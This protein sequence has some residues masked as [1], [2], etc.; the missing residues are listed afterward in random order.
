MSRTTKY[1]AYIK[2]IGKVVDVTG[3][4]NLKDEDF[5]RVVVD[6]PGSRGNYIIDGK[7]N[8]LM[9]P[10]GLKDKNGVEIYEGYIIQRPLTMNQEYHGAWVREEIVNKPGVW[11]TSHVS[12][13]KGKLPRGYTA[14]ELLE[15]YEYDHKLFAL[16][17]EYDMS[18]EAEII[19]NI[20][21]NPE[22][23]K[24]EIQCEKVNN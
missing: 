13:E 3:I 5:T 4:F 7:D 1:K 24:E 19:G 2:S 10:T 17:G 22:L 6:Y 23:L 12:S 15:R 9:Q 21:E 18:T 20:Y 14:G 11:F 16:Y 8:H